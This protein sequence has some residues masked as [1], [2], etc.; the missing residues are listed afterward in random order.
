LIRPNKLKEN[1]QIQ[2]QSLLKLKVRKAFKCLKLC[3]TF[4]QDRKTPPTFKPSKG[5]CNNLN[6][7]ILRITLEE[8]HY[9]GKPFP[10]TSFLKAIKLNSSRHLK[11]RKLKKKYAILSTFYLYNN[12]FGIHNNV[13]LSRKQSF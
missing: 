10:P 11:S 5:H 4:L 1:F 13:N 12:Y 8:D 7:S 9:Q 6:C 3:R 2:A